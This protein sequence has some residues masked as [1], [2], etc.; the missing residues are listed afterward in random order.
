MKKNKLA[1][2][3]VLLYIILCRFSIKKSIFVQKNRKKAVQEY[4][5]ILSEAFSLLQHDLLIINIFWIKN[6]L[7]F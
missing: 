3:S 7:F 2:F 4:N 5:K 1:N 6:I